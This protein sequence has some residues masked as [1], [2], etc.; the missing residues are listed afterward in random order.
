VVLGVVALAA[1][2]LLVL[3][4]D[5]ILFDLADV[6]LLGSISQTL[7]PL[8]LGPEILF[9]PVSLLIAI[10]AIVVG[11]RHTHLTS[12]AHGSPIALAR[13]GALLGWAVVAFYALSLSLVILS[14]LGIL[15]PLI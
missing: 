7:Y 10:T 5:L 15:K 1:F 6:P 8:A 12:G 14:F 9:S 3:P 11:S 13:A 2:I 4:T